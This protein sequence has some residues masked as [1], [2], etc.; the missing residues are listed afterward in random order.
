M[1]LSPRSPKWKKIA[2]E[3]AVESLRRREISL[4][5]HAADYVDAIRSCN[6]TGEFL[7]TSRRG[8]P[9]RGFDLRKHIFNALS[10]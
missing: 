6:R 8:R 2:V 9:A 1:H 10:A 5:L 3:S 4:P 7:S